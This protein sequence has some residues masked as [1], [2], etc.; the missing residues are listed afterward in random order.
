MPGQQATQPFENAGRPVV[1]PDGRHILFRSL[2]DGTPD[3]Y[4]IAADGSGVTRLTNSAEDEAVLGWNDDGSRV[5]YAVVGNDA[6]VIHS[7]PTS[8]GAALRLG[9]VQGQGVRIARDGAHVV[10]GALP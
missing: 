1:A 2:R 7:M 6:A 4:L 5:Y 3:L 9:A 10:Y 8:G